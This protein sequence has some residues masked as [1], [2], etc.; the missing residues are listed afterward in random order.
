M[1][2]GSDLGRFDGWTEEQIADYY[3]RERD[4]RYLDLVATL[5]IGAQAIH[6]KRRLQGELEK[7]LA[8]VQRWRDLAMDGCR[9][10]QGMVADMVIGLASGVLTVD[11]SKPL[12]ERLKEKMA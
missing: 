1:E 12:P 10:Q 2:D 5:A 9:A 11:R 3:E 4:E 7:A 6:D 8:E